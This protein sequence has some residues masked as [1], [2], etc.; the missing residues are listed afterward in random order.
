MSALPWSK[1]EFEQRLREKGRAYHI[2]HPFNVMLNSG[3]ANREQIRGWV[4]DAGFDGF[5]EVEVFS[6]RYWAMDQRMY[7]ERIVAAYKT[8]S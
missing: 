1:D 8:K 7:L 2:H 6:N 4:E 3:A 5:N